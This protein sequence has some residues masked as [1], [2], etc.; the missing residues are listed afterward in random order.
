M[1]ADLNKKVNSEIMNEQMKNKASKIEQYRL[2]EEMQA[3]RVFCY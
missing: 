3:L 2:K 1:R